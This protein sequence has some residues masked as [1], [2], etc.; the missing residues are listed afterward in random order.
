[1]F[2]KSNEYGIM[3]NMR[4]YIYFDEISSTN[5]Y[6]KENY[7]NLFDLDIVVAKHQT[8]GRGRLS[9]DW[10]DNS[11]SILLSMLIKPERDILIQLIPLVASAAVY[12]FLKKYVED[13]KIKWPNDLLLNGKKIAGILVEAKYLTKLEYVVIGIGINLNDERFVSEIENKATSL[14]KVTKQK[15]DSTE[16]Y[17]GLSDALRNEYMLFCN[18]QSD[19]LSVNRLNSAVINKDVLLE[20][21]NKL[22]NVKVLDILDDGTILVN[23]DS[24]NKSFSSGEITLNKNY[25]EKE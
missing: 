9:R 8:K 10:F 7:N 21:D 6:I 3:L 13:V 14:F 11:N 23:I 1:M 15:Y 18:N 20:V 17:E 19:F 12:K 2:K 25:I 16:M 4:K 24:Q 5:D 22:K